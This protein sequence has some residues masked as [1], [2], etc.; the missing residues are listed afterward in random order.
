VCYDLYIV[1]RKVSI[2]DCISGRTLTRIQSLDEIMAYMKANFDFTPSKR[3]FQVQFKRWDFPS[4]QNPAHRNAELVA[5]VKELWVQ[6]LTQ[7][8]MLATLTEEGYEL[9]ERELMRV[10]AKNRWLLRVPNG[11]KDKL[12]DMNAQAEDM[13]Q[14][15]LDSWQAQLASAAGLMT[16]TPRLKL[17]TPPPL[18]E[19]EVERRKRRHDEL[20]DESEKLM[21]TKK[22]RRRTKEWAGLPADP[23]GAPP[24]F[25]S[26]TTLEESKAFLE[27][28]SD[29][30]REL[31]DQFQGICETTGVIKK[32]TSGPDKW[33]A[34][35]D[36]L[37]RENVELQKVFWNETQHTKE[38]KNLALD[39]ICTDVTKRMRTMETRMTIADAKNAMGIN[40]EESRQIRNAYYNIL[41]NDH[42]ESKLKAGDEHWKELKDQW[43]KASPLLIQILGPGDADPNNAKK[44]KALEVLARDVMKRLRDDRTGS[45]AHN[46]ST[47]QLQ[48]SPEPDDVQPV[49]R[50]ATGKGKKN[51]IKTKKTPATAVAVAA[52]QLANSSLELSNLDP[53]LLNTPTN[54][55][56]QAPQQEQELPVPFGALPPFLRLDNPT[57]LPLP[58]PPRT[59]LPPVNP[60]PIYIRPHIS[61]V[62]PPGAPSKMFLATLR[63]PRLSSLTNLISDHWPG[64]SITR[65]DGV[66]KSDAAM[67]G[68]EMK[69]LIEDDE[70]LEAYLAHTAGRK[71]AFSVVLRREE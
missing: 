56:D 52:T 17:G 40:P 28:S 68:Q 37:V 7:R 10:R 1:Q 14:E 70:E 24:R 33:A 44:Q 20:L 39:V 71:S 59:P 13:T 57:R 63:H 27:L 62:L 53:S 55:Q 65:I 54:S 8:E 58:M 2:P 38:S 21:A 42:F 36:Q 35:K 43:I 49:P 61:S 26:E 5:R 51:T 66:E 69:Y 50:S 46:N 16:T 19:E 32:T 30:Y 22:R 25:P 34:V 67:G 23:E 9:K 60:T 31:R 48:P 41:K 45:K 15:E 64:V 11:M 29:K 6:N 3:A 47:L 18:P 12:D 4:K